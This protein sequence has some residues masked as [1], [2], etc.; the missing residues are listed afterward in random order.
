VSPEQVAVSVLTPVLNE[1]R[2]IREAAAAM[3]AQQLSGELELIFI[4]GR[5]ED[6]TAAILRELAES[7]PRIKIL[8][9]PRRI[10]PVALNIGLAAARG[11]V[12]AR[13][14]A[15][16]H[17]PPDYLARGLERLERGGVAHVSGP[18]IPKGEG[19]WSR[20]VALALSSRLGT[21]E[22]D[23][24]HISDAEIEVDSGFTGMWLRS[25][26]E[27]HGGWD[28][29]WPNDQDTE[30]AARIRADGGRIV[31][32]PGMAA[33]Y[34]PRDSLG[35]LAR[36]YFRYGQYRCKTSGAHPE[37]MRRS[38]VIAPSLL[39]T[40]VAAILG[41]GAIAAL[42]R[43]GAAAYA[44]ALVAVSAGEARRARPA[45][46]ASLPLV[47]ATMHVAWG[48]GFLVGC[49]RFGVPVAA[50]RRIVTGR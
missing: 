6:A 16:T 29:E 14:D 49:A 25:T 10:T 24:R 18:Q 50:V 3:Q 44:A 38:H 2:A 31:C 9:N 15:H 34:V 39:L 27:R 17:Y 36:Q 40:L 19:R 28:E 46:A 32:V 41:R 45:D 1:E 21:G 22:A 23:F 5:S 30:L 48:V 20:R 8:D 35:K 47:F 26:L 42:A 37:S 12:I 43:V 11:K 7:D 13:M 4:D 33:E